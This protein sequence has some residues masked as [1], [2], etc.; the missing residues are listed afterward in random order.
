MASIDSVENLDRVAAPLLYLVPTENVS[1]SQPDLSASDWPG[2]SAFYTTAIYDARPIADRLSVDLQGFVLVREP[3]AVGN[4]YDPDEV[5]AVYYP[6]VE[7]LVKRVTG[8]TKAVV[9]A[10]DVRCAPRAK[11]GEAGVREPVTAVHNDY[12]PRSGPQMVRES[13]DPAEAELLIKSRFAEFN[14]WRP[15]QGPVRSTPL[16]VCDARSIERKDLVPVDLKHEVF[17]VAHSDSHRW[18][19]IERM[20]TDEVLLIKCFDSAED[21]R[22]RFTAHA[23]FTDPAAPPD[24]P[25]RESIEVR[26]LAFFSEVDRPG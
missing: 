4:F 5:H 2:R 6:E 25:A 16:A 23:A 18:F 10:H 8:A 3:T 22:A 20:Q 11:H 15:I 9:F 17:M 12:T 14:V 26:V 24:A 1:G 13:L 21:G 7:T 19:F